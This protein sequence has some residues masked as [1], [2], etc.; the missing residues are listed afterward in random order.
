MNVE[1]ARGRQ[2]PARFLWLLP[3]LR[4]PAP[5]TRAH[6]RVFLLVGV[7]ALFAGYDQN[8][9]SGSPCRRSR[10]PCTSRKTGPRPDAQPHAHS[11]TRGL[12][13]RG[14]RRS[15]RAAKIAAH[16]HHRPGHRNTRYRLRHQ[17]RRLRLAAGRDACLRLCG[18][19]AL[20]CRH[21]RGSRGRR[22]RLGQWHA[23]GDGLD[24]NRHCCA[25]ASPS[26]TCCPSAG[27]PFT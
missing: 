25:C 17:L 8:T 27:A 5:M 1:T 9:S 13:A 26:S 3:F 4:P 24:R 22:A 11:S 12:R 14:G 16:H 2:Q 21:R 20:L 19:N 18:R 10:R 23:C 6:E 7:A 15:R